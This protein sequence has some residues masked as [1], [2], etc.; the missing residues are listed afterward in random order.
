MHSATHTAP[1][2]AS[3]GEKSALANVNRLQSE[4]EE[5]VLPRAIERGRRFGEDKW[6]ERVAKRLGLE[7]TSCRR[8]RPRKSEK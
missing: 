4:A 7:S 8:G 3:A 2:S 5:K 6:V 1:H